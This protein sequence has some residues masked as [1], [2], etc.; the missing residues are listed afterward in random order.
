MVFAGE[1]AIVNKLTEMDGAYSL[2]NDQFFARARERFGSDPLFAYIELGVPQ[3]PATADTNNAAYMAGAF[4]GLA[5]R[6][7]GV[8][9]GGGVV[10]AT[11]PLG[12]V[13]L[14]AQRHGAGSF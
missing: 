11:R 13:M 10:G 5:G 12:S 6:P 8:A 7:S 2:G 4:A 1:P 14:T 9:M 3:L